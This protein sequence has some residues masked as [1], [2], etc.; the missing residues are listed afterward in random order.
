MHTIRRLVPT[1]L[2]ILSFGATTTQHPAVTLHGFTSEF[3]HDFVL[4]GNSLPAVVK[5]IAGIFVGAAR[6]LHDPIEGNVLKYG[7][8]CHLTFPDSLVIPAEKVTAGVMRRTG[9]QQ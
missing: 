8:F 3:H 2:I 1:S 6:C 7:N 4:V 9:L 5:A